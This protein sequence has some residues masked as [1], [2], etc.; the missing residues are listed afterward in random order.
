MGDRFVTRWVV[1]KPPRLRVI[2]QIMAKP[3]RPISGL[4][5]RRTDVLVC[6]ECAIRRR[7]R[8]YRPMIRRSPGQRPR[9]GWVPPSGVPLPSP[10]PPATP[11]GPLTLTP[12]CCALVFSHDPGP[13]RRALPPRHGLRLRAPAAMAL[14]GPA[15][16]FAPVRY[17]GLDPA[18][19]V[20]PPIARDVVVNCNDPGLRRNNQRGRF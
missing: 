9:G 14:A 20:P 1:R 18:R 13:T 12:T 10:A 11:D 4:C 2:S 19:S 5:G 3:F 7:S 8:R 15:T 6:R 16:R 17:A